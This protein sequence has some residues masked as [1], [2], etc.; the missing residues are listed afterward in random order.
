M[1]TPSNVIWFDAKS[2]SSISREALAL[3]VDTKLILLI[4]FTALT[5]SESEGLIL[6]EKSE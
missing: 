1:L 2:V 6:P 5:S 3:F 4:F